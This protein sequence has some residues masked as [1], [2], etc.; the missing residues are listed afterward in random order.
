MLRPSTFILCRQSVAVNRL[1]NHIAEA[2]KGLCLAAMRTLNDDLMRLMVRELEGFKREI[3]LFPDDE[4]PWR[5]LP[6]VTNS[7]ANL[8]MHVAGGLQHFVGA[9]L[10]KT[11]Y[12]RN[13]ALEFSRRS[14]DRAEVIA[15]LDRAIVTVQH[16]M[17]QL[18]DADLCGE[19][20]PPVIDTTISVRT[21]LIHLCAHAAMHL[22]QAGYLRRAL[23]QDSTS[24]G[25]L[26]FE[27]LVSP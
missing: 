17:P 19:F 22:G 21:F 26:P 10:G 27:P 13:R 1:S 9:L 18:I 15:E 7:A 12:V 3:A 8:A 11:G 2:A 6:G 24:S 5:T 23:M 25:P 4:S 20:S 16:V 14:G